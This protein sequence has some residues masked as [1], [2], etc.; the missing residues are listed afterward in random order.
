MSNPAFVPWATVR[1][2]DDGSDGVG[3]SLRAPLAACRVRLQIPPAQ[4]EHLR[5]VAHW[6]SLWIHRQDR[7]GPL[8][9]GINGAQGSGKSTLAE[10]IELMLSDGF[11]Y[12]TTRLSLDDFYKTRAERACLARR[13]HPLLSTRGVPGSHDIPLALTTVEALLSAGP[14]EVTCLPAFDK[15]ADERL[16]RS[17]WRV[18]GGRA[19]IVILEGWCVGALPEPDAALS[20]P[21]NALEVEE[22]GDGRWRRW[23]NDRLVR[24]YPALFRLLDRLIML[25]VPDLECVYRWR[26]LQE[27]K[28]AA[29]A[30]FAARPQLMDET[31]IR[32][33]VMHFERLTR[34]ML[35]EM[36]RRADLTLFLDCEHRFTH[37]QR[38]H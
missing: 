17:E 23:V 19:D 9:V 35:A 30:G 29:T 3:K 4:F 34:A 21:I 6:L 22:D 11:G 27:R 26:A 10:L 31:A 36:P 33:F 38:L 7:T 14:D 12:R 15:A 16:A 25:K 13:V 8:V 2:S 18:F 20:Q 5:Q 32:R 28:L 24:D 37:L 1:G